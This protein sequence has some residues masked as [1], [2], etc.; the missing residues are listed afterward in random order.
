MIDNFDEDGV[1]LEPQEGSTADG[2]EVTDE[3]IDMEERGNDPAFQAP[4]L[5]EVSKRLSEAMRN[6][7]GA[8]R[9]V[10]SLRRGAHKDYH[11]ASLCF[12]RL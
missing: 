8:K 7:Q 5:K 10:S 1:I 9:R 3:M 6:K 11:C 2:I 4:H 12:T